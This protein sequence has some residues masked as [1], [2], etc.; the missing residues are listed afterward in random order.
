MGWSSIAVGWACIVGGKELTI[1]DRELS[2][3][4]PTSIELQLLQL[5]ESDLLHNSVRHG[6]SSGRNSLSIV[7]GIGS[8]EQDLDGADMM[9]LRT[10]STSYVLKLSNAAVAGGSLVEAAAVEAVEFRIASIFLT[11]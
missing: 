6:S 4:H 9:I 8:S 10:S 3:S 5:Q 1:I 11:K 2:L 7:V